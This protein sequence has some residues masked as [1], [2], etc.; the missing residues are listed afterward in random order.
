MKQWLQSGLLGRV[1]TCSASYG[2]DLRQSRP[3]RDYRTVY[4]SS[5]ALGGGIVLDSV[6]EIDYLSWFFGS[7]ESVSAMTSKLSDLEMDTEDSANLLL[8]FDSGVRASIQL[9]Y[10][11]PEYNRS[12]EVIGTEGILQWSYSPRVLRYFSRR[13]GLWSTRA[14]DQNVNSDFM[15]EQQLRHFFDCIVWDLEPVQDVAD[16]AETLKIALCALR[17]AECGR[18]NRVSRLES[19]PPTVTRTE[20]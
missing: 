17:S 18:E 9:D 20:D 19:V 6:H 3:E 1:L 8:R 10:F 15:Y 14:M 2:Q 4:A 7:V 12:C 13:S 11:R 16:A 5:K